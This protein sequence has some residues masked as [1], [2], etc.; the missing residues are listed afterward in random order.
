MA[1]GVLEHLLMRDDVSGAVE[2][3]ERQVW[4]CKG[5]TRGT[6]LPRPLFVMRTAPQQHAPLLW[7]LPTSLH[8]S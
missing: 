1:Q 5:G 7:V 3:V 2:L 4:G 6:R 8:L